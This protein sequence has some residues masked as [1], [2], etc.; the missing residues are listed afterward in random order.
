MN[1]NEIREMYPEGTQIVLTEMRGENQMPYGLKGTVKF[2]DDAGQIHMKW[3]N[4]SSLAL[5]INEDTF[6]KVEAP[7]K[8]SVILVEPGRYPKLIEIEDTLEAMQSLV[9]GDIEEYMPFDDE[10]A[11]ICNEEGK[12]R[13]LPLN[14]A[15]YVDNKEMVDII[16]GKFFICYAPIESEKFLSIPKELARKYEEKFKY[17]ER[18]SQ[19]IDGIEAKPYKPVSKDMER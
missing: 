12:M 16:A 15:V 2:V 13:G 14:R 10:V 11:I 17:P 6:E 8:I 1:V 19:T 5:N 18:F 3:E 7:Q 4:G 9:E